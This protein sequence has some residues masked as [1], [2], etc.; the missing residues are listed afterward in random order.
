M[1][2]RIGCVLVSLSLW[3]SVN[4]KVAGAEMKLERVQQK[5]EDLKPLV[6][7]GA[8]RSAKMEEELGKVAAAN[9]S[10]EEAERL[11]NEVKVLRIGKP[12][13]T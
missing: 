10:P 5:V 11:T 12:Y 9:V 4:I 6:N 13:S 8:R 2:F 1:A 3:Q 7:Q